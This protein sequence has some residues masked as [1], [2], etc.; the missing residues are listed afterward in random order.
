MIARRRR[1]A[2]RRLP[3]TLQAEG[4]ECGM[5]CLAMV[6]SYHGHEINLNEIRHRFRI[7]LKGT[8]LRDL[9]IFAGAMGLSARG[10][11]LEPA[12]LGKLSCPAILHFDMSHFVVLK[13]MS[14]RVAIIHDP[15]FGV[16]RIGAEE[17]NRRFTGIALE[18]EPAA[19]FEPREGGP[20]VTLSGLIGTIPSHGLL[21]KT[22]ALSF[23]VQLFV[24]ASPLY[25]QL[26]VDRAVTPG[27][28]AALLPLLAGF[29][30]FTLLRSSVVWMRTYVLLA[31]GGLLNAQLM[32]NIVRHMLRLPHEWFASRHVAVLLSRITSTQPVKDLITQA[33]S[34]AVV[35]GAMAILT[36]GVVLLVAPSLGVV[37]LAGF[38]AVAF[39]NWQ[40][41]RSSTSR[42]YELI[43]AQTKSQRE[44]IETIRGISAVKLFRQEVTRD[45]SWT[46]R[47]VDAINAQYERDRIHGQADVAR[48]LL[49]AVTL[50]IV[51]YIGAGQVIRGTMSLGLLITFMTYQ[52]MFVDSSTK[53]L[54]FAVRFRLLKVHLERLADITTA[55]QE[56]FEPPSTGRRALAGAVA[57]RDLSFSYGDLEPL[58]LEG[59][60]LD[61]AAGEFVAIT[62]PSGG[63]KTTLLKL[64]IGLVRPTSGLVLYDGTPLQRLG[65]GALRDQIGVVMQDDVL[66]TG[67]I[68][69]NITFFDPDPDLEWLHECAR[70]AAIDDDIRN[71]P[72]GYNTLTGD[73]GTVLS[74]GQKQR[75][76]LARALYRRPVILFMDEGTSNLDSQKEREVNANLKSMSL[77]RIIIAHRADTLE[78]ADYVLELTP[79]GLIRR[80]GRG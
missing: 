47:Q 70:M 45:A 55:R 24:L 16:R 33:F 62:G 8:T 9:V 14:G 28:A 73:M 72:M 74:G 13:E 26:V 56:A 10:L 19:G 36:L 4:A 58:V 31:F 53:L 60:S 18:L 79:G 64:L 27:D 2:S 20:S 29:L 52:Q 50:A 51:V 44:L 37:M 30:L 7:S 34:A 48:Q 54:E 21:A 41:A 65:V 68:G 40:E 75:V 63:G 25:V 71:F 69:Q 22:L 15:G 5:A 49:Q 46:E 23:T 42:E 3:L 6:A 77:T 78:A 35:D 43:E 59:V 17:L 38:S 12:A 80:D 32:F 11:R 67:S 57:A 76:L 61:V 1:F 66:M 39:V